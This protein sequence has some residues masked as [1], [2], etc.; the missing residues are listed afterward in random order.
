MEF[1]ANIK[2]VDGHG[3][4]AAHKAAWQGNTELVRWLVQEND[5]NPLMRSSFGDTPLHDAAFRG[6]IRTVECL[7]MEL[8]CRLDIANELHETPLCS[9]VAAGHLNVVEYLAGWGCD[10]TVIA[11]DEWN[12]AHYASA[13]GHLEVLKYLWDHH[14]DTVDFEADDVCTQK[15]P[16]F[17]S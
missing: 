5:I 7:H 9:A 1:G 13:G 14:R 6:H 10:M 17:S 3:R 4:T 12:L 8:K 16:R 2:A 15:L 11:Q